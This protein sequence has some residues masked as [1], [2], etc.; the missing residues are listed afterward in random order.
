[1]AESTPSMQIGAVTVDFASRFQA[2]VGYQ[3]SEPDALSR[4]RDSIQ[5]FVLSL[6]R[7]L[8][9]L[10]PNQQAPLLLE[11]IQNAMG[12]T[13]TTKGLNRPAILGPGQSLLETAPREAVRRSLLRLLQEEEG[14]L[15]DI[16]LPLDD[17]GHY[18]PVTLVFFLQHLIRTLSEPSLFFLMLVLGGVME[19]YGKIGKTDDLKALLDAPTYG[20]SAAVRYI[21]EERKR[22]AGSPPGPEGN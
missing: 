10:G 20:F 14:R 3:S 15:A 8:L 12:D 13:V 2:F 5:L 16:T 9:L 6:A 18:Y 17:E 11:Y 7:I 21:E 22:G 19:Y 4:E 1:M